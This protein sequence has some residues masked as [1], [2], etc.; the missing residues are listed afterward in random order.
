MLI[1]CGHKI[2]MSMNMCVIISQML[3]LNY[4]VQFE[5][6]RLFL[7]IIELSKLILMHQ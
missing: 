4:T 1:L 2:N 6:V 7:E 3:Y 5:T